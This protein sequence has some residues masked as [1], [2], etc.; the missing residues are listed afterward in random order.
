M[1]VSEAADFITTYEPWYNAI[2]S[3]VKLAKQAFT[4]SVGRQKIHCFFQFSQHLSDTEM[5]LNSRPLSY[6]SEDIAI[7]KNEDFIITPFLLLQGRSYQP[8]EIDFSGLKDND[9]PNAWDFRKKFAH[10]AAI[11]KRIEKHYYEEYFNELSKKRVGFLTNRTVT[12][13]LMM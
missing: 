12:P 8:L 9:S 3:T 1:L 2:E 6:L 7:S 5:I 11:R 10:R 4:K 13:K